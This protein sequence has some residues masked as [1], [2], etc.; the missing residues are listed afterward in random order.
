MH[1]SADQWD[2]HNWAD[3]E[4]IPEIY[5][6]TVSNHCPDPVSFD[7]AGIDTCSSCIA[8]NRHDFFDTLATTQT[9][10]INLLDTVSK[11]GGKG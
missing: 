10:T 5:M 3:T 11:Y 7:V 9:G 6:T 4:D 1:P 8:L 2:G